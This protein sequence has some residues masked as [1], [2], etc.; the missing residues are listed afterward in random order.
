MRETWE[1]NGSVRLYLR[2]IWANGWAELFGLGG[3]LALGWLSATQ[4]AVGGPSALTIVGGALLAI[5]AGTLLEGILIGYAQGR[6]LRVAVPSIALQRWIVAT[7][8]GAAVAWTLGMIPSTLT[9]LGTGPSGG[10][11]PAFLEG[12][13]QYLLAAVMG[14]VLGPVL[15]APQWIVLRGHLVGAGHW[16]WA[17]ALAWAVGMPLVFFGMGAAAESTPVW[18]VVSI[19]MV[20]CLGTGLAVGAIHGAVLIRLT[21]S[22]GPRTRSSSSSAS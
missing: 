3:T 17:N 19:V 6:V 15:A 2:W 18:R 4:V 22:V 21:A 14:A 8:I 20:T 11:P 7:A 1:E 12:P 5:V 16:L 13:G 9:S 10:A